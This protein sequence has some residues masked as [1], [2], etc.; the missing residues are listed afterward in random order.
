MKSAEKN[1]WKVLSDF[2]T[3][4]VRKEKRLEIMAATEWSE[5]TFYTKMKTPDK[6][7]PMEKEVVAK[8]YNLPVE[9]IF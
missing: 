3:P 9:F 6:L 1:K 2:L 5:A 8:I 7:R 4:E